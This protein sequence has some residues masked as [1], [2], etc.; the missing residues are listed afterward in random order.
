MIGASIQGSGHE[1]LAVPCQ[2]AHSWAITE[3]G[4]LLAAIADGAGS[5]QYAEKGAARAVEG[6]VHYLRDRL[7]SGTP[8][9]SEGYS[10]LVSEAFRH[11]RLA[12]E[13]E[14]SNHESP[15]RDFASTLLIAVATDKIAAVGQIGDGAIVIGDDE[16]NV[17]ALT[18]PEHG[19]YINET[20]FLTGP[21]ALSQIQTNI[22]I[23]KPRYVSLFSDGLQMLALKMPEGTP[24]PP[25]FRPLF[26]FIAETSDTLSGREDLSS[27]LFSPRIRSRT[28]DDLTLLVCA[29][30]D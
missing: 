30:V 20:V 10:Q 11:A 18:R 2:D 26:R 1:R 12:V 5:A 4:V 28:D 22:W 17:M 24:H 29:H 15:V 9:D 23:G 8:T 13:Q 16:D 6:A 14:A 19:E 27:F 3:Q 7:D 25:F 21:Q